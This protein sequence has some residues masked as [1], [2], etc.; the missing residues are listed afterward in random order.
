MAHYKL[1]NGNCTNLLV[2]TSHPKNT[3][4]LVGVPSTCSVTYDNII[5]ANVFTS[6]T[7]ATSETYIYSSRSPQ[8][9]PGVKYTF[10]C[11]MWCNNYVNSTEFFWLSDTTANPKAGTGYV[12]ITNKSQT[13][14]VRNEWFHLEWTFTTP[15]SDYTG[16]IRIDNNGSK[17][18]GMAAILKV[19]NLK[20]EKGDKATPYGLSPSEFG[21]IEYDCSGYG[22]H[23][24]ASASM[25]TSTDSPRYLH[26]ILFKDN[27]YISI[28]SRSYVG[29]KDSYTFSYWAKHGTG[30]AMSG[31]MVWGFKDGGYLDVY[32]TGGYLTWNTGDG[33]QNP[34]KNG[35]TNVT[36][37]TDG[38]WHH[39][40]ITGD[41][42]KTLLYLD[43]EYKG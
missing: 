9:T 24:T 36:Y 35:S 16:Y 26:S 20:L 11:D 38:E 22:N 34:F 13:I 5:E 23:G 27:R 32:P 30:T 21:N 19:T 41:G 8:V 2:N 15:A 43:G 18:A 42:T 17:T 29:M 6:T 31:K 3:E 40:T 39:Y 33:S 1:D 10:S 25:E 14:P 37:P 28:P 4:N 12:T 7:T